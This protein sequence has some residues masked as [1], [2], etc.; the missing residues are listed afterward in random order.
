MG[1][2]KTDGG[3]CDKKVRWVL[4]STSKLVIERRNKTDHA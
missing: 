3:K 1:S 2:H 4:A